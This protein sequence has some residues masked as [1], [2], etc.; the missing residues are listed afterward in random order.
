MSEPISFLDP[1][2]FSLLPVNPHTTDFYYYPAAL[3]PESIDRILGLVRPGAAAGGPALKP[4]T[5]SGTVD[6]GYRSSQIAWIRKDETSAWLYKQLVE[7]VRDANEKMWRFDV[8][9][10][11]DDIQF[12]EYDAAYAG[13]YDWHMDVGGAESSTRKISISVQLSDPTDYDGGELEFM[14]HR[15]VVQAERSRGTVVLFPSF[16]QH[17]VRPVTRGVRRSLVLWVHGP[18]FR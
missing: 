5:V 9:N 18:P 4:G 10:L 7:Y 13:H 11:W 14:L 16:L 3:P 17:R 15:S 2:A 1:A 6:P 8:T 12:T